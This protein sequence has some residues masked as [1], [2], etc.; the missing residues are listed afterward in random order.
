MG[1]YEAFSA[2]KFDTLINQKII[3]FKEKYIMYPDTRKKTQKIS[4][5]IIKLN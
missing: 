1:N 5:H 4:Y 3:L 2:N